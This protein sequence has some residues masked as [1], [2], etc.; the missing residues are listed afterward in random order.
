[1]INHGFFLIKKL[2]FV[3]TFFWKGEEGVKK[4]ICNKIVPKVR[5]GYLQQMETSGMKFSTTVCNSI[6]S[7]LFLLSFFMTEKMWV[8]K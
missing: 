5:H 8:F 7:C 1:M 6:Y 2:S 3:V 4:N